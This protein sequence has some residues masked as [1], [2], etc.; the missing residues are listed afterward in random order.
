M[1]LYLLL[2]VAPTGVIASELETLDDKMRVCEHV[3][4]VRFLS[5][6]QRS[7]K[8][9]QARPHD[10][11]GNSMLDRNGKLNVSSLRI[12]EENRGGE[13]ASTRKEEKEPANIVPLTEGRSSRTRLKSKP[14]LYPRSGLSV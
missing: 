12:K 8:R 13:D 7:G 9:L 6:R 2:I 10:F 3:R 14:P 5:F 1:S 11:L 4:V